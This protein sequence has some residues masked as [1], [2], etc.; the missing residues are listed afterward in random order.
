MDRK[1]KGKVHGEKKSW[2]RKRK[3]RVHGEKKRWIER[4]KVGFMERR[5]V[6]IELLFICK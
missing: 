1:R 6:G 5:K 2:D 4:G 3:G